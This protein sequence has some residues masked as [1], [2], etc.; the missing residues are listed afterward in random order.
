M[1]GASDTLIDVAC[2]SGEL[3]MLVLSGL[4]CALVFPCCLQALVRLAPGRR[5]LQTMKETLLTGTTYLRA[6][7]RYAT[8]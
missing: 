7:L 2:M 8:G 6:M 3:L 4:L 5:S 1:L